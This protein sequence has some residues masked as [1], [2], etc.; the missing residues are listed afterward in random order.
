MARTQEHKSKTTLILGAGA[1]R[2]V[3]YA[4]E[5][6]SLSPLDSDFYEL[7]QRLK[8]KQGSEEA[9]AVKFVLKTVQSGEDDL[10]SSMEKMFYTLHMRALLHEKL[11]P[12][13]SPAGSV[14]KLVKSFTRAIR[15]LLRAAHGERRCDHHMSLVSELEGHDAVVTFNYDLVA[16]RAFKDIF[17]NPVRRIKFGPWLYGF[18]DQQA[19]GGA[20]LTEALQVARKPE[21]GDGL[22]RLDY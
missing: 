16:E 4:S 8:P 15:S 14:D 11:L 13:E 20:G 18:G 17:G 10:W 12:D 1:S 7:L 5:M 22:G 9:E 6:P 3:S 2:G 21:L 19:P